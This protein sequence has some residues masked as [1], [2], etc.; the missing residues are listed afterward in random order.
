VRRFD[1]TSI[2]WFVIAAVMFIA[3]IGL[4]MMITWVRGGVIERGRAPGEMLPT[5][6]V[7][8]LA[9]SDTSDD[10]S[11]FYVLYSEDVSTREAVVTFSMPAEDVSIL[12]V[13]GLAGDDPCW[14]WG[15][16]PPEKPRQLVIRHIDWAKDIPDLYSILAEPGPDNLIVCNVRALSRPGSFTTRRLRMEYLREDVLTRA[17]G[18]LNDPE[19]QAF[20]DAIR[21]ADLRA[22]PA[23]KF[24]L[25]DV[26]GAEN[27]RFAG[28]FETGDPFMGGTWRSLTNGEFMVATWDDIYRQQTRDILLIVI[29]TL[30]GIGVT[31]MIEG[32][33]PL[34]ASF[35]GPKPPPPADTQPEKTIPPASTERPPHS[36]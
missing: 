30:I 36:P 24:D 32:L 10:T 6:Y 1:R 20:V 2:A 14:V 4:T 13:S 3:A 9:P 26:E 34:I 23:L 16:G 21:N 31:V 18:A 17:P 7:G 22:I 28:S 27:M 29:G 11:A 25:N 8:V 19:K 35:D 15:N 12:L 33:R 5:Q